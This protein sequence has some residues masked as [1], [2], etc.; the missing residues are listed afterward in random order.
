MPLGP[1]EINS[2][3]FIDLIGFIIILTITISLKAFARV[4][5]IVELNRLA[6]GEKIV[7]LLACGA[8]YLLRWANV[9]HAGASDD[10]SM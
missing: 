10:L 6:V 1:L 7:L 5:V 3:E 4:V 8:L 9:F 2:L